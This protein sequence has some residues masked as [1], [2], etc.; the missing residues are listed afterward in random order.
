LG[1][2]EN[3]K[4]ILAAAHRDRD[5]AIQRFDCFYRV[6]FYSPVYLRPF[7]AAGWIKTGASAILLNFIDKYDSFDQSYFVL[8]GHISLL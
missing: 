1:V 5:A 3:Q 2:R 4:T 8:W 6:K 7:L